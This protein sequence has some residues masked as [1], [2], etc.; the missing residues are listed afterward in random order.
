MRTLKKPPLLQT[1]RVGTPNAICTRCPLHNECQ[2][3]GYLSQA[4]RER[5][6]SKVVYAWNECVAS[7]EIFKA[8]VK[9]VCRKDEILIVDEVNPLG[10]TQER[11]LNRDILFDLTERFRQH[12]GDTA[13]IYELLKSLLDIIST[14]ETPED[15]I[16]SIQG[17]INDI[18]DIKAIDEKLER[19]PVGVVFEDAP[20]D[21]EQRRIPIIS[22]AKPTVIATSLSQGIRVIHRHGK[23]HWFFSSQAET[24]SLGTHSSQTT[25]ES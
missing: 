10:L 17:F 19:Y 23:T 20:E 16:E 3:E 15:F 24:T 1:Q 13:H 5:K 21:A 7:D 25:T 22:L 12:H 14:S 2:G 8:R 11:Y 18:E 9:Q 4:K 6:A